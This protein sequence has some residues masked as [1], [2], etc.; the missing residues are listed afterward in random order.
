MYLVHLWGPEVAYNILLYS[1][2]SSPLSCKAGQG[3][4][5]WQVSKAEGGYENWV[6]QISV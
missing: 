6:S 3:Y 2:L 5:I 4:I 1:I